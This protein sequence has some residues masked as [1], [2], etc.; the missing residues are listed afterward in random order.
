MYKDKDGFSYSRTEFE[1]YTNRARVVLKTT[2]DE[3]NVDVYTDCKDKDRVEDVLIEK[4]GKDIVSVRITHFCPKEEDEAIRK[5]L[6]EMI[7]D[8]EK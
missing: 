8:L 7:N 6:D 3:F 1:G 4:R 5:M 2:D